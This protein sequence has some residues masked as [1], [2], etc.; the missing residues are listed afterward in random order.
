VNDPTRYMHSGD[1]QNAP[2]FLFDGASAI[3][4]RYVRSR[5]LSFRAPQTVLEDDES[6]GHH[7]ESR[8]SADEEDI[9]PR[10]IDL[11]DIR[12]NW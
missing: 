3:E 8:C 11:E 7:K 6:R 5:F 10:C 1:K 2:A 9:L 12:T 4:A